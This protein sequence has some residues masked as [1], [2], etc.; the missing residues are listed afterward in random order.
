VLRA[1]HVVLYLLGVAGAAMGASPAPF[2]APISMGEQLGAIEEAAVAVHGTGNAIVVFFAGGHLYA[3]NGSD[4]F[5]QCR[6]VFSPEDGAFVRD[7]PAL[8]TDNVGGTYVAFRQ[9]SEQGDPCVAWTSSPGGQYRPAAVIPGSCRPD[10]ERP[11]IGVLP[12]GDA[13][14]GWSS[15]DGSGGQVFISIGGGAAEPIL[16]GTEAAFAV[17]GEGVLHVAYV[18]QGDV[19]YSNNRDGDFAGG[20]VAITNTPSQDFAPRIAVSPTGLPYV[21]YGTFAGDA[22]QLTIAGEDWTR[23]EIVST[24]AASGHCWTLRTS[25]TGQGCVAAFG[26]ADRAMMYAGSLGLGGI[27]QELVSAPGVIELIDQAGDE[28]LHAHLVYIS[29]MKLYYTNDAP[30]PHADFTAAPTAGELPLEVRLTSRSTGHVLQYAWDFGDGGTSVLPNPVHLYTE[31]GT[32]TIKLRVEG[33]AAV[34]DT[35]T[36]EKLITVVPKKNHFYLPSMMVYAGQRGVKIP[37]TAT[38]EIPILGFQLAGRFERNFVSLL[39]KDTFVNMDGTVSR[40]LEPEFIAASQTVNP[41][42]EEEGWFVVGV[43]YD[44]NLPVTGKAIPPGVRTNVV[45]LTIDVADSAPHRTVT[46]FMLEDGLGDPP[47]SN[48]FMTPGGLSVYPQLHNGTITIIR[49]EIE[50]MGPFFLRGDINNDRAVDLADVVSLLTYLF[51][52]GTASCVDA[53]DADDNQQTN[54]ADAIYLLS[55]LFAGKSAP[56]YPF[57]TPGLDGTPDDFP[58]CDR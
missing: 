43:I 22:V 45:N 38:N 13:V 29:D 40:S 17:D 54:I 35:M 39:P 49:R 30:P 10:V 47:I 48:I 50:D 15:G 33:A 26:E 6:S 4:G 2:S 32:Y 11:F 7:S 51:K 57:P 52:D 24:E 25:A 56:A 16:S 55:Y 37:V 5:R 9:R 46:R 12:S 27:R 28:Y 19:F 1:L 42:N 8:A 58:P 36:Q 18:R 14:I 21:L 31:D 53:A 20:E 34:S 23:R 44:A 41:E 3:A